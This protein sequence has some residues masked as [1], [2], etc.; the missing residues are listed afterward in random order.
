MPY[1][2]GEFLEG[3]EWYRRDEED[4][5]H[6]EQAGEVIVA[7]RQAADEGPTMPHAERHILENVWHDQDGCQ[8][9]CMGFDY[10]FGFLG[11]DTSQW[12][13]GNLFRN[14]SLIHPFADN[15]GFNLPTAMADDAIAYIRTQ[16]EIAPARPWFIHYAP[17]GTHAPHQ[18]TR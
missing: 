5:R 3:A 1:Q 14:T 2:L 10:L 8:Q 16:T 7:R 13:P 6:G 12:R 9:K 4:G 11:G 18:P 17:G 15:P